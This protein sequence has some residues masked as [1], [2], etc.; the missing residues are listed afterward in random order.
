M[1]F[2]VTLCKSIPEEEDNNSQHVS[3]AVNGLYGITEDCYFFLSKSHTKFVEMIK[4]HHV[5]K[6]NNKRSC[7]DGKIIQLN[8][9]TNN[10][11]GNFLIFVKNNNSI[12]IYFHKQKYDTKSM[13]STKLMVDLKFLNTLTLDSFE[14]ILTNSIL[15]VSVISGTEMRIV[16]TSLQ[17]YPTLKIG[18]FESI[19]IHGKY[20]GYIKH[21]LLL[22]NNLQTFILSTGIEVNYENKF[23]STGEMFYMDPIGNMDKVTVQFTDGN[24]KLIHIYSKNVAEICENGKIKS[25]KFNFNNLKLGDN[26]LIYSNKIN[27]NLSPHKVESFGWIE[28]FSKSRKRI[29]VTIDI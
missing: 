22:D 21:S 27:I 12:D 25:R 20:Q 14:V 16:F 5:M 15:K 29:N 6:S 28:N 10:N 13:I 1:T 17:T 7:K 9:L 2:D 24:C 19:L 8:E 4:T 26:M 3:L 18:R 11:I 23:L